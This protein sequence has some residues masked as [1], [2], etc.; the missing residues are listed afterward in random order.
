MLGLY[1]VKG[2]S[3]MKQ[4]LGFVLSGDECVFHSSLVN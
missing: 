2:L 3:T 1:N 4:E